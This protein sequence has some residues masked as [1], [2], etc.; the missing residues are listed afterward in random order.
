MIKQAVLYAIFLK[1]LSPI[2][3]SRA[4]TVLYAFWANIASCV[5]GLISS[6]FYYSLT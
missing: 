5:I 4:V 3:I 6:V 1:S 2:P